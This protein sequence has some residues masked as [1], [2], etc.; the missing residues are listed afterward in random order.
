MKSEGSAAKRGGRPRAR[1]G[2]RGRAGARAPE[3]LAVA[4][5]P[6]PAGPVHVLCSADGLREIRLG[7]GEAPSRREERERN[8]RFVRRA[9]WTGPA[10]RA[11]KRYVKGQPIPPDLALDLASGTP[12][13]R[14]VWEATRRVPW[15]RVVSYSDIAARAGSPAAVRAVGN[16]LGRNPVPIV[17]PCHRVIHFAGSIGGFTSGLAWKRYLL[18]LE[19]GQMEL[20]W[21][22]PR[23][24]VLG[25][26]RRRMAGGR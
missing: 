19:R 20:D 24:G 4:I 16:A 2:T 11:V 9:R 7:A 5:V 10:V 21:S 22:G 23:R 8:V 15:G 14:R 12:F 18:G 26:L 3:P 1:G 13:Q 25:L 17:V 6:T